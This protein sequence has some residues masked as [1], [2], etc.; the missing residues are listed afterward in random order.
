MARPD[1][2]FLKEIRCLDVRGDRQMISRRLF[3]II[4]LVL[5]GSGTAVKP[6]PHVANAQETICAGPFIPVATPL[7]DLGTAEYVRMDGQATGFTGGLY[8]NG[9]NQRP[10]AHETAGQTIAASIVPLDETGE[11]DA[12]GRIVLI[13]VGMSNTTSEFHAFLELLHLNPVVNP[14]VTAV[15]GAQGGRTADRWAAADTD[16]WTNLAGSLN[17]ARVTPEQV[18]VAWIKQTVT[19]GG[20]FPD[21]AQE[22]EGYL[23]TIVRELKNRF[24]NLKMVYLSSRTRSYTYERGLSPEPVAYETAFAVKWLIERQ[25]NGDPALNFDPTRGEVVAP[26]LSWGPYLWMDG[27]NERSDGRVWL[28]EDMIEDCTHPSRSGNTKVGEMLLEFFLT[29][30]TTGWFRAG[31]APVI[32][33]ALTAT[34]TTTH[35]PLPTNTIAPT[36]TSSP[37]FTHTATPTATA[38]PPTATNQPPLPTPTT[39]PE[40]DTTEVGTAVWPLAILGVLIAGGGLFWLAR[41]HR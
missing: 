4:L 30:S 29:D 3:L 39:T 18:Q 35:T 7:T 40:P 1:I 38:V 24:P 16:V 25:I 11:P 2:R 41:R 9:R 37:T 12:D 20:E 14:H 36:A 17:H 32:T 10:P 15:N 21:R 28:A 22:L 26:Y 6:T 23:E 33:A 27:E 8:P 34:P 13:S 31:E 19:R 5:L